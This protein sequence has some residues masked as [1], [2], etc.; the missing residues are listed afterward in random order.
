M[1]IWGVFSRNLR[2][3]W[4][5]KSYSQKAFVLEAGV[6]RIYFSPLEP[7]VYSAGI[8]KVDK[9]AAV[10][11]VETVMPLHRTSKPGRKKYL[12]TCAGPA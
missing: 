3:F 11:D 10:L 8:D 7:G 2:R 5:A 12:P 1:G 9:P 4:H 6:D